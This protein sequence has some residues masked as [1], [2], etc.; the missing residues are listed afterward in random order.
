[1][2]FPHLRSSVP[3]A[4]CAMF[5]LAGCNEKARI[6]LQVE[7]LHTT[8]QAR[9]AELAKIQAESV[10]LGNLGRFNITQKEHITQLR[11]QVE[12]L[13]NET[14]NIQAERENAKSDVD[15][16]QRELDAYRAKHSR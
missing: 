8:V 4:L 10:A 1:M 14:R 11:N 2:H 6:D 16:M 15:L 3:L 7:E 9:K 13:K 5:F 12:F